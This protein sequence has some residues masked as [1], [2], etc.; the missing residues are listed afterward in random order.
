ML[1]IK[2]NKINIDLPEDISVAITVENPMFTTD[3]L[4]LPFSLSFELPPTPKN[5]K[6]FRHINRLGAHDGDKLFQAYSC[7]IYFQSILIHDGVMN[8]TNTQG[9]IKVSFKG[10]DFNEN[11]KKALFTKDLGTVDFAGDT[12]DGYDDTDSYYYSYRQW[13]AAHAYNTDNDYIFA[14][15]AIKTRE[16]EFGY[17]SD[18]IRGFADPRDGHMIYSSIRNEP[19][20]MIR[21]MYLNCFNAT[22]QSFYYPGGQSGYHSLMF[23]QFRLGYIVNQLIGS[24][25]TL[26]PFDSGILRDVVLPTFYLPFVGN[27]SM[28]GPW[29]SSP[30][31]DTPAFLKLQDVMPDID[32]NKFLQ[33]IFN[34]FCLTLV[35]EKGKFRI[36]HNRDIIAKPVSSNWSDKLLYQIDISSE[37]GKYYDYGF[38]DRKAFTDNVGYQTVATLEALRDEGFDLPNHEVVYEQLFYVSGT[39]QYINKKAY[40]RR[41]LVEN[42]ESWELV[43]GYEF[44]GFEAEPKVDIGDR[45]KYNAR[46]D[47]NQLYLSPA[48]YFRDINMHP[49]SKQYWIVPK[50]DPEHEPDGDDILPRNVRPSSLSLLLYAGTKQVDDK[51]YPFLSPYENANM[52]LNWEG[53]KG[54]LNLFHKEF[55][56]WVEKSKVR[57]SGTFLLSALELNKLSITD[58]VHFQGRNFYIEK[59]QYT[60]RRD[61]IDPVVADLIEV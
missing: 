53:E 55:K 26:S 5:L 46:T 9:T 51:N 54:L 28:S 57:L 34:V 4:P 29:I 49:D 42:V 7:Q 43:V 8:A 17:Y 39:K 13:A 30:Y 45:D 47:I 3:K 21:Y 23:P 48:V 12:T 22:N 60:I 37:S 24:A 35:A 19:W 27:W 61:R 59:L 2:V 31:K 56:A 58:K 25:L 50:W 18:R 33:M 15:I 10:V 52:S 11:L 36:V 32:A 6:V 38:N 41:V 20:W 1:E 14:P 40:Y 44:K 16:D